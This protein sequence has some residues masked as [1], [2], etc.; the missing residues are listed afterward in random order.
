MQ[1]VALSLFS[2]LS[3]CAHTDRI[4]AD[5]LAEALAEDRDAWYVVDVRSD[6][7]FYGPKGHI[8]GAVHLPWPNAVKEQAD[9]LSPLPDQTVVLICFTG[10]RSRWSLGAVRAAVPNEVIDL[11]GGMI[12]WWA[13]DHP[14]EVEDSAP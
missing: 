1:A 11:K 8:A 7:E 10:H 4:K 12:R 9:T 5:A 2:L 3:G 14:V 6:K 13:G